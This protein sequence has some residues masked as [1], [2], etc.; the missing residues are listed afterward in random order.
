MTKTP[1]SDEA[2]MGKVMLE[3]IYYIKRVAARNIEVLRQKRE[4]L[5]KFQSKLIDEQD[6]EQEWQKVLVEECRTLESQ[7]FRCS[8]EGAIKLVPGLTLEKI[9]SDEDLVISETLDLVFKETS[10]QE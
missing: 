1:V 9:Y 2:L 6:I 5:Q 4:E 7:R 3:T 10:Q 8:L